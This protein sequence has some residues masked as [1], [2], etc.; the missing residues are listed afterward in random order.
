MSSNIPLS[1]RNNSGKYSPGGR[2]TEME[3]VISLKKGRLEWTEEQLSELLEHWRRHLQEQ[4]RSAGTIKKYVEA[5]LHFLAWYEREEL[6]PLQMAALTPIV[7][8]GYRNHL[9][10]EQLKSVSTINLRISSLRAWCAWL[11]DQGYLTANP[12]ARVK[13]VSGGETAAGEGVSKREGLT[14]SQVNALLRQAQSSRD[15]ER[16]YAIVQVLL[17]TGIRLSECSG[18]R[19]GDIIFG[20][21]SGMLLVRAGKGN[22]A[23][24]VPLNTSAREALAIY[25]APRLGLVEVEGKGGTR[26]EKGENGEKR[27][28]I[29]I[30]MPLKAVA[31]NWPKPKSSQ[32]FDPLWLS[33]KG[34]ALTTSAMGQM[35][36][37]L[38]K[39]AGKLVPRET[40]AHSL[41]HTFARSYLSQYPGDV[42]GLA[43]LLGH[44]SLDTT[45]LYSQPA[46]S[47]LAARMEKLSLNA[48]S[49]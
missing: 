23:R 25:V 12:S 16:N 42:V 37:D 1:G 3:R 49:R 29:S 14:S 36:A 21:R 34:G 33:Q 48:Y 24:T 22:K 31:A 38:V 17:Q 15:P 8:I 44:S 43:T 41:R 7:L 40:T 20:E 39:A 46:V 13:L 28:R 10:H 9:Q 30:K 18:L 26:E 4:D 6:V 5:V 27:E 45:R 11:L 35:M 2:K 32:S 19:F 47:Q